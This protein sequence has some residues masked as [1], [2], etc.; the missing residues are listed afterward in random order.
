M[1]E[2]IKVTKTFSTGH[3]ALREVSFSIHDQ[4]FVV[5][6]GKSGAGKTT[7]MRLLIHDLPVSSGS[8]LIDGK[9]ITK[10]KPSEISALRKKIAVVFQ[11]GKL[12][13]DRTV[14]ENI[15]LPMMIEGKSRQ[16][17]DR[18]VSDLLSLVGLKDREQ[19]FPVQLSGGEQQRV[20]IARALAVAPSLIF[21]DEPT[22]NLDPDSAKQI[23]KLFEQIQELGV[24]VLMA[25]HHLD[26]VM[27]KTKR[28]LVLS[29]GEIAE[30]E[31][32][33]KQSEHEKHEKEEEP[34]KH[35]RVSK[36]EEKKQQPEEST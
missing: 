23:V 33:K 3:T 21:A 7:I 27:G 32:H 4:E 6:T 29:E 22:G 11:D 13:V 9:D 8:I 10:M 19:F 25:T 15:A 35:R 28:I 26:Q 16:E 1:I 5:L 34:E 20:A 30:R 31:E 36:R 17:I 14:A 12:L 18:K 2:F 24:S